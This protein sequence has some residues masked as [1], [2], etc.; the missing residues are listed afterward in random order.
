MR[1]KVIVL[2][3]ALVAILGVWKGLDNVRANQTDKS[4]NITQES[5]SQSVPV[6]NTTNTSKKTQ[7]VIDDQGGIQVGVI[8]EK[9]ASSALQKFQIEIN[10]HSVNLDDYDFAQ[11]IQLEI[12]GKKNNAVVK[13]LNRGGGGHH[14]SSEISIETPALAKLQPGDKITLKVNKLGDTPER[15]F[16]FVY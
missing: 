11:N 5:S 9:Q 1:V 12:A 10:N 2:V 7:P 4:S 6:E 8:W 15:K 3:L 14:A 13:V 16:N